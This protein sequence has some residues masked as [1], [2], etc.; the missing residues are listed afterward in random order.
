MKANEKKQYVIP[1]MTVYNMER[2]M[3]LAGS[4]DTR[5]EELERSDYEWY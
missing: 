4:G 5:S 2:P 1:K 3:I